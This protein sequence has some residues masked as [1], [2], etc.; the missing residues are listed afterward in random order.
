MSA[1]DLISK[2]KERLNID[3]D[4]KFAEVLGV[5]RMHINNWKSE[6]SMPDGL[7]MLKIAELAGLSAHDAHVLVCQKSEQQQ[8]NLQ[9]G[10]SNVVFLS[11]V[12]A[13]SFGAM[14]I[15][16]LSAL[17]YE[18]I[19]A[20][21]LGALSMYI[22]L[23]GELVHVHEIEGKLRTLSQQEILKLSACNDIEVG[24]VSAYSVH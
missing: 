16:K 18:P 12:S 10:F 8:L 11:A 5:S 19:V 1:Y 21:S 24:K 20:Q 23:N 4:N 17:P 7:N 14:S 15:M 9:A 13:A 6:R 22:M 2:A 3:S